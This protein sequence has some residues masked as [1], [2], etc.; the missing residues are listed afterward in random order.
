VQCTHAIM[1]E[2]AAHVWCG[3]GGMDTVVHR[4]GGFRVQHGRGCTRGDRSRPSQLLVLVAVR[5]CARNS[6]E[7]E[8]EWWPLVLYSCWQ[9]LKQVGMI[10]IRKCEKHHPQ[11]EFEGRARDS[12]AGGEWLAAGR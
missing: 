7:G 4:G 11:H 1:N 8:R 6:G 9:S 3:V 12:E 2:G 10:F 5:T